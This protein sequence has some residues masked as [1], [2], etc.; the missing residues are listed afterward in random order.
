MNPDTPLDDGTEVEPLLDEALEDVAGGEGEQSC[1]MCC[2]C[3]L[4][5]AGPVLEPELDRAPT[6]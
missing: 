6:V 1:Y 3:H 4:C 5:S 2:S